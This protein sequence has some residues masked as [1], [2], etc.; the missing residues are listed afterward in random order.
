MRRHSWAKFGAIKPQLFS[1]EKFSWNKNGIWSRCSCLHCS[2]RS[3][4]GYFINMWHSVWVWRGDIENGGKGSRAD[5]TFLYWLGRNWALKGW[6]TKR[7]R[8]AWWGY[9]ERESERQQFIFGASCTLKASWVLSSDFRTLNWEE[10][11]LEGSKVFSFPDG[12]L[13]NNRFVEVR[14]CLWRSL[15][16]FS[17]LKAGSVGAGCSGP[18]LI[19]NISKDGNSTAFMGKSLLVSNQGCTKN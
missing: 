3:L 18:C 10:L 5:T 4:E 16:I 11:V 12:K 9:S 19:S 2:F 17:V 7:W 15:N 1:W 14:W 13:L 6:G 8:G